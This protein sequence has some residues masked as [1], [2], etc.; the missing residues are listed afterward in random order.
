MPTTPS[1]AAE[2]PA[3]PRPRRTLRRT[4][5]RDGDVWIAGALRAVATVTLLVL[6][7][8]L[9]VL[10]DNGVGAFTGAGDIAVGSLTDAERA[11]LHERELAQ[12]ARV[13]AARPTLGRVFASAS[14]NPT[15]T[16]AP[17]WGV[18]AMVVSTLGVTALAMGIAIPVGVGIALWLAWVAPA[19]AREAFKP[20]LELLAGVPS[21]VVGFVGLV[22]IGPAIAR[23]FGLPNGLNALHGAILLAWMA[24]PTIVAVS[25]DALRAVPHDYV[26]ASLALGA[27]R[28][29]TLVRVVL[30][31]ARGGVLAACMLGV[32]RAI[33][34]TM[35]VLMATGNAVA[36]PH[37]PFDS[38]RT[39]TATVAIELGEVTVGSTHYRM[40]FVVGLVLLLITLVVNVLAER[41]V[42]GGRA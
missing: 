17:A 25:E 29:Q 32:G 34:E 37:G 41:F 40:L 6:A 15:S 38:V 7:G 10:M 2:T 9:L 35:T 5:R 42:R 23:V 30:P 28:W 20:V 31:A 39:L 19:W 13:E 33:G 16:H 3:A 27:D 26:R 24:L 22:L 8:I 12:L 18:L 11:L 36:L 14:W 4:G 1:S 21:V